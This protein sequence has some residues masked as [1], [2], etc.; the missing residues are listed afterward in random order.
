MKKDLCELIVCI[1]ESGSMSGVTNDT[2]GGF[3][4]FVKTHQNLPGEAKLT[5]VKFNTKYEIVHNGLDIQKVPLLDNTTYIAG[6]MTA[7]LDAVGRSIDEVGKRLSETP[8]EERPEKVIM[9]II[10][11]GEENSSKEYKLEQIKQKMKHQQD[12]YNWEILFMGAD[13]DAW[14]NAGNMG[15]SNAINYAYADTNVTLKRASVYSANLRSRGSKAS[16]D[17]FDLSDD[18]LDKELDDLSKIKK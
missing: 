9:L 10:T 15:I 11:D 5:L 18:Q 6:G 17:N 8:E 14:Q 3:N 2:I 4:Q 7:L 12:V 13:Q 16:L 1:D